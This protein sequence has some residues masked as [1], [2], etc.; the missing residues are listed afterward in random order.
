MTVLSDKTIAELAKKHEMIE[1]FEEQQVRY[2]DDHK[3]K[4]KVFYN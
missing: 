2:I 4:T 1:P 3:I